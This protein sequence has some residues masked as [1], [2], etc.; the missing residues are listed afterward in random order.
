MLNLLD[1]AWKA[2]KIVGAARELALETRHFSWDVAA[3]TTFFLQAEHADIRLLTH[4]SDEIQAKI[5]LQAGFGWQVATDQDEAGV[6]IIA[7]RKPLIGTIGRGRLEITLPVHA[8]ISLKL[9]GCQL[10]FAELNAAFDLPPFSLE[11]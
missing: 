8:H 2:L 5:E 10:S 6:Y 9:N 7:R 3:R 11:P 4:Q 1:K